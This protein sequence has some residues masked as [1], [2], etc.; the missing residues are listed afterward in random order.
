M[1]K[2]KP[3][4]PKKK[5]ARRLRQ[6]P[7]AQPDPNWSLEAKLDRLRVIGPDQVEAINNLV[8]WLLPQLW[9]SPTTAARREREKTRQQVHDRMKGVR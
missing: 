3:A 9:P 2:N 7:P 6:T 4:M 8:D 5:P 1:T